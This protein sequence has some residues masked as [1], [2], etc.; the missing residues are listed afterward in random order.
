MKYGAPVYADWN[1]LE[2]LEG[3]ANDNADITLIVM[4][5]NGVIYQTIVDDPFF[6]AHRPIELQSYSDGE[7]G[8]WYVSDKPVSAFGCEVQVSSPHIHTSAI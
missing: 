8:T 7:N 2:P 4:Q 5:P 6:A 1:T 3:M